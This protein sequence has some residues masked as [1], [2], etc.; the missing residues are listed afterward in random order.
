MEAQRFFLECMKRKPHNFKK[1][2]KGG[3]IAKP[4]LLESHI[5][6]LGKTKY[7]IIL[8]LK[9]LQLVYSVLFRLRGNHFPQL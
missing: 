6:F 9:N 1:V 2:C 4:F 3:K 8:E 7:A 5:L